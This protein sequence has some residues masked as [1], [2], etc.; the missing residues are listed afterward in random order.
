MA[1]YK[2]I[3]KEDLQE[4]AREIATG[5][6]ITA[7]V[8]REVINTGEHLLEA[9][10]SPE[11]AALYLDLLVP[12]KLVNDAEKTLVDAALGD[13]AAQAK[14]EHTVEKAGD[15]VR[16]IPVSLGENFAKGELAG[17]AGNPYEF[18]AALGAVGMT[19]MVGPEAK[20][21]ETSAVGVRGLVAVEKEIVA[22]ETAAAAP[23]LAPSAKPVFIPGSNLLDTL[24]EMKD[25]L[26]GVAA[27]R[28]EADIVVKQ[29][30]NASVNTQLAGKKNVF[31][32]SL[33]ATD[34]TVM[35][36]GQTVS[37]KHA[38]DTANLNHISWRAGALKAIAQQ[39]PD[40]A[41]A[42]SGIT[43][44]EMQ[45]ILKSEVLDQY[46]G[47]Q[48][49][50]SMSFR[51]RYGVGYTPKQDK[52]LAQKLGLPWNDK[53]G[54]SERLFGGDNP[55]FYAAK[56][57][58]MKVDAF[59][60]QIAQDEML[61][62]LNPSAP[63]GASLTQAEQLLAHLQENDGVLTQH[64]RKFLPKE[65]Q[66]LPQGALAQIK[67]EITPLIAPQ[68]GLKVLSNDSNA[69]IQAGNLVSAQNQ[70]QLV[71]AQ[72]ERAQALK[73]Q[74]LHEIEAARQDS[75]AITGAPPPSAGEVEAQR[76][77][78]EHL[79]ERGALGKAMVTLN[80]SLRAP[81]GYLSA[82]LKSVQLNEAKFAAKSDYEGF[83]HTA[84][85]SNLK[86]GLSLGP[87]A[88]TAAVAGLPAAGAVWAGVVALK[89]AENYGWTQAMK[90]AVMPTVEKLGQGYSHLNGQAQEAAINKF[91]EFAH[92][93]PKDASGNLTP[94]SHQVLQHVDQN[95]AA[96]AEFQAS[97][98]SSQQK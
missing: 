81:I 94:A 78:D 84:V 90:D 26:T 30:D 3:I 45:H 15:F 38:Y 95:T 12:N 33:D 31:Q 10:T 97:V 35:Y 32:Q 20:A 98:V 36:N 93:L 52:A 28:S 69:E 48:P 92:G 63:K 1:T 42:L 2:N 50:G 22:A 51:E 61:H 72:N 59:K 5:V 62:M 75:K 96:S 34:D 83:K 18:G 66:A 55:E 17:K 79:N 9:V 58:L 40:I 91:L 76:L 56:K 41:S 74:L 29:I 68:S 85:N 23:Q 37:Q 54:L 7:G 46:A 70:N 43:P 87:V 25:H 67:D 73:A 89:F 53:P 77:Y 4:A 44:T 65:L 86:L 64:A 14:L 8:R 13:E 19:V 11:A 71:V 57:A 16:A 6:M 24:L 49:V 47:L 27:T 80:E 39:N 21:V 82:S 60:Q 88:V